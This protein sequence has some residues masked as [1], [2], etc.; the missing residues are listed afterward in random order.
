MYNGQQIITS[1]SVMLNIFLVIWLD[2]EAQ[3]TFVKGGGG[4]NNKNYFVVQFNMNEYV[5]HINKAIF[6]RKTQ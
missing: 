4:S 2:T 1:N 5:K 6:T 3:P